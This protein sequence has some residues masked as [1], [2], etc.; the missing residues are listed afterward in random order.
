METVWTL[1]KETG[2]RWTT[3]ATT[4]HSAALAFYAAVSLT[5]LLVFTLAILSRL[6]PGQNVEQQVIT[7]L[8]GLLGEQ[9]TQAVT[10]LVEAEEGFNTTGL[11]SIVV[12]VASLL[13]GSSRVFRQIQRSLNDAWNVER[14]RDTHF[15]VD[16]ARKRLLT[17]ALVLVSGLVVFIITSADAV[18]FRLWPAVAPNLRGG[19]GFQVMSFLGSI[20]LLTGLFAAVYKI[21]PDAEIRWK[22]VMV[23]S[24]VTAVLFA[25]GQTLISAVLQ[26]RAVTRAVGAAGTLLLLLFWMYYS[27]RVFLWGAM[28]TSV[29]SERHDRPDARPEVL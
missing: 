20:V 26:A 13:W 25:L 7:E 17:V 6:F 23:G 21:L 27:S 16:Y 28:F 14:D 1:I 29:Y 10:S 18:L 11:I 9:L 4:E 22:D 8:S 12:G 3:T 19:F 2:K 15:V 24:L 5:P